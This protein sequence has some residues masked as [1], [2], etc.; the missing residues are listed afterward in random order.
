MDLRL[1]LLVF[2]MVASEVP[3]IQ[4]RPIDFVCDDHARRDMNMV[5]ELEAAMN[6]CSGSALLPSSIQLPCVKINK[7][8]WEKKS[9]QEKRGDILAA[10]GTLA[11]GVRVTRMLTTPGCQ[12][13][14][15][16]RLEH[17]ITNYLHIVTHLELT[18]EAESPVTSCP[19]QV[20]QNL[21]QV[22]RHFS[23][24]LTG[25]LEWLIAELKTQ[26]QTERLTSNL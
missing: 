25:K 21:G 9:M 13:S 17:S 8:S 7:A 16:E 1:L 5:K 4:T 26:C 14:L 15:L 3:D 11:Q 6:D 24:L 12:F 10:L 2:C 23:W 19:S 18:G 20:T 22:L